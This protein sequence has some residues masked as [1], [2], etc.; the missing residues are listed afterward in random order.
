MVVEE[1]PALFKKQPS[2][3]ICEHD[4]ICEQFGRGGDAFQNYEGF[5]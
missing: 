2:F 4:L 5:T 3:T 1:L